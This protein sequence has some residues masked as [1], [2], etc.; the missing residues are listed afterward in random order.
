ML[1][2]VTT[3]CIIPAGFVFSRVEHVSLKKVAEE[4]ESA[5]AAVLE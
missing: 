1:L 5:G 3:V 2:V 4:S